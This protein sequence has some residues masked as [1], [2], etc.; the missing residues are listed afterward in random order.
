MHNENVAQTDRE[1]IREERLRAIVTA[2][3]RA[4]GELLDILDLDPFNHAAKNA[5]RRRIVRLRRL[6]N[7]IRSTGDQA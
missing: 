2:T 1:A 4:E 7:L 3:V 5:P 6:E